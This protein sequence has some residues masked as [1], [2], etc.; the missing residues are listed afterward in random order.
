MILHDIEFFVKP[1]TMLL[2]PTVVSLPCAFRTASATQIARLVISLN[3]QLPIADL[4]FFSTSVRRN[5]SKTE[6]MKPGT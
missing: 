1:A 5:K 6:I 2:S 4:R 3:F